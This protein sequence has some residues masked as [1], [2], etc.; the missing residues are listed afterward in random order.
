[1]ISLKNK[2]KVYNTLKELSK[3]I[4]IKQKK[5]LTAEEIGE[6]LNIKRNAVS[7]LLNELYKEGKIIKINTR[8]VYFIDKEFYEKQI[9]E[10]EEI[11]NNKE[12]SIRYSNEDT[13]AKL[14][15]YSGSLKTQVKL[16][17]SAA[18]YP[19]NG[20]PALL[21]GNTGVGKSFMAQ[22]IYEYAKSIN[23]IDNNAPY[24]IFNCS[25]YANNAELLAANIFGYVKGAFT[26]AD[27][28]KMGLLEEA[29]GGYLFLDEVHRL[30]PEGQEKLFLFLD[31]GVFRRL[32]ETSKWRTSRVRFIFA[33]TEEPEKSLIKT[34][35]RRIPLV[36][37]IPSLNERPL[38]ERLQMIYAFYKEESRNLGMD[39]LI[40]NQV[41]NVLLKTKVS[42]NI[43]KMINVI[44]YSCAQAYCQLSDNKSKILNIHLN[45]L[46]QEI[47]YDAG[48][49]LNSGSFNFNGM[50][51][52]RNKIDEH[53]EWGI[54][55]DKIINEITEEFINLFESYS[56]GD[57]NID[58]L[59]KN[60][61][62]LLNRFSDI[63]IFKNNDKF[64][65]SIVY[66]GIKNVI[67]N[68]LSIIENNYGIKYYGNTAI[69]FTHFTNKLL[70]GINTNYKYSCA[71]IENTIEVLK[72]LFFKEFTI[73]SKIIELIEK[74]LDTKL[75]KIALIYFTLYIK[76]MNKSD[77]FKT[78]NSIIIAHGYSTASSIAS[79]AN[80]LLGQ[81]IFEAF[82][83]PIDMSSQ[84]IILKIESYL[85]NIDTSNGIIILVDMG[86]LEA[87]YKTLP[88][89][90]DGDV[91][92]INNITTQLALDVGNRI[93]NG[94]PLEQI[95]VESVKKNNSSFKFIKSNKKK[96]NCIITTCITGIGTAVNIKNL[97][98]QCLAND[99]IEIIA[100]DYDRLKG[101]GM[102]DEIFK[103]YNVKL[104]IGTSDPE[105]EKIPY[106]SLEELI[107]GRGDSVLNKVLKDL[108]NNKTIEQV[109][110][111]IIK[112]FSLQN[113]LGYLT[114]I[115]PD[116]II[117]QVEKA[118]S[119][120]ELSL[121]FK[122]SNDLKI[123]LY[124]H[125]SCLIER[126]IMKDPITSYNNLKK[127]EECHGKFIRYAKSS[128]KAIEDIYKVEIPT[129][130]IGF[131]YDIIYSKVKDLA[132]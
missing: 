132:V 47:K 82:D 128:L 109:N 124:I 129:S 108:T 5:G 79:V 99:N 130:E 90:V 42:G 89:L 26:G 125:I 55:D 80:R 127:F 36:I 126:L 56:N 116:K 106:I 64:T 94:Q 81:F 83:M 117:E 113:V 39:I 3:D 48:E 121:N 16:C 62:I 84:E 102:K 74:N 52:S 88:N 114:I 122:F 100:Y 46:P 115:N 77:N 60:S 37:N 123:G 2:E 65:D 73:A 59:K 58:V 18:S 19:P 21:I 97:L 30:P 43:G 67:E 33:T 14:I 9:I 13:F 23:A 61:F 78:I 86:S 17:K 69:I 96:K 91:A 120:L 110:Q 22:L 72:N 38:Y 75:D 103:N 4:R 12:S 98:Q 20:L 34:F 45:D 49:I 11:R 118:I 31:K 35:L 57:I 24:V 41:L 131:I 25:E 119:N 66:N 70:E 53:F 15:G 50:L 54:E 8:P 71:D 51:I 63:V 7:H 68:I 32:G 111:E 87:I 28:D 6:K 85:K 10:S 107:E 105:I 93:I 104:I 101:N 95:V 40:S 92:I 27:R 76:S 112:L 1:M 29:D 44:K